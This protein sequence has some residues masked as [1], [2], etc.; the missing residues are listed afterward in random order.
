[1]DVLRVAT[2]NCWGLKYVSK[3]RHKRIAAIANAFSKSDHDIIA[4][5]ELWVEE[6]Y[7]KIRDATSHRL[8]YTKRFLSG[9][10]GAGLAMFTK[11]PI[12]S[13]SIIPYSLNGEPTDVTGGDWFVGKAVG[14][15]TISHPI[16]GKVQIFNTHLYAKGGEDG[17]EYNRSHRLVN[18]WQFAKVARE[19]AELG[20]YVIAVGDFN[21]IPTSLPMNIVFNHAGLSDAWT[22]AHQYV[23]PPLEVISPIDGIVK[24]GVTADSP[25]NSYRD[26]KPS[27]DPLIRKYQGK[28]LDYILFRHPPRSLDSDT[29]PRLECQDSKVIFTDLIPEFNCSYSDHFGVE[30]TFTATIPQETDGFLLATD[31]TVKSTTSIWAGGTSEI[32]LA[33]ISEVLGTLQA[34]YRISQ[35]RSRYELATFALCVVVLLTLIFGSA[36]VP[37]PWMNRFFT[38]FTVFISWLATTM[39]YEGFIFGNWERRALQNT[40]EE[41]ELYKQVFIPRSES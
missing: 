8:P 22:V 38:F 16:L 17:P 32:S 26:S 1:M 21:S 7:N 4:L 12:I 2:F 23:L 5:Q 41:L 35:Q 34:Y 33:S 9:A 40:I 3:D 36:W 25:L 29:F 31:E 11:W 19:A 28:R 30:A 27:L 14:S 24:Y 10:L 37:V 39:L 13:T 20:N 6:D 15:V 18:A